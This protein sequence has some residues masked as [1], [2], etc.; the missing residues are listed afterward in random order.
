MSD[1]VVDTHAHLDDPA[2]WDQLH[3]V[4]ARAE[5][6]GI[7]RVLAVGSD[8]AS[9]RKSVVAA[10]RFPIVYAAVGMHPHNADRFYQERE[11]IEALLDADKVVAVGETGLDF[12]R[13]WSAREAQIDAFRTQLQ[14]ARDRAL[15]ASVHN[16]EADGEVLRLIRVVGAQVVMHAFSTSV[17]TAQRAMDMGARL[18]FAGNVTFAKAQ[19][20]REVVLITPEDRLLAETDSPVLAPQGHRGR[21]NEPSFIVNTLR[22]MAE[23]RGVEAGTL[24]DAIRANAQSVFQ[25]GCP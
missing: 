11:E 20:L 6:A 18:S 21:T 10:E 8:L 25:W 9:S 23:V 13:D 4:I 17:D 19:A 1:G 22:C 2:L 14:W 24:R 3:S 12:Y 15:P 5:A 7:Q 16:R